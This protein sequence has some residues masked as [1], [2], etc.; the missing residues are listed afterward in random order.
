MKYLKLL[1]WLGLY[2]LI[3]FV[4]SMVAGVIIGIGYFASSLIAGEPLPLM[5]FI[6]ENMSLLL[7]ISG[8]L[9]LGFIALVLFLRKQNPIKYLEFKVLS[10]K[11]TIVIA[12]TGIGFSLFLNTFLTLIKIDEIFPDNISEQ[13]SE[14]I[15]SNLF[16]VTLAVGIV[17]PI[18]EEIL[19]RGMIFKEIKGTIN[20]WGALVLQ[21]LLFGLFHG[22][23]LQFSYTFPAGIALG[24]IYLKYRSIWAPI[25]VHLTWNLTSVLMSALMPE[26][27]LDYF[28]GIMALGIVLLVV[29]AAYTIIVK[30][31]LSNPPEEALPDV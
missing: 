12:L 21:G 19:F 9:I 23:M 4:S 15:F 29:G 26:T 30:P 24:I 25:L 17:V 22:N 10:F 20:L 1:G 2:A 7:L 27:G 11:D 31:P 18:Y 5:E 28:I 6:T 8:I 16:L 14:L 13:L 3:Y